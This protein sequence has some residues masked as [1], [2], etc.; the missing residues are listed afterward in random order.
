MNFHVKTL[1]AN[2]VDVYCMC[3]IINHKEIQ[4]MDYDINIIDTVTQVANR[5]Q[6]ILKLQTDLDTSQEKYTGC[7]EEVNILPRVPCPF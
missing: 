2:L 4:H 7:L 5:D 1:F 3:V 6:V